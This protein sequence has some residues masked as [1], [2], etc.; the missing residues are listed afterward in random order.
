M[1]VAVVVVVVVVL[2]VAVAVAVSEVAVFAVIVAVQVALKSSQMP[3][4]TGTYHD[5]WVGLDTG[6]NHLWFKSVQ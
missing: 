6:I 4:Q 3:C 2:A 5:P 1:V